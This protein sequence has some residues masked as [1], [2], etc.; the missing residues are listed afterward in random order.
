MLTKTLRAS[1]GSESGIEGK[2]RIP[3][4]SHTQAGECVEARQNNLRSTESIQKYTKSTLKTDSRLKCPLRHVG[5]TDGH[6]VTH[7]FPFK[8]KLGYYTT[9]H[10][11]QDLVS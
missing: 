3:F 11:G 5:P 9:H 4:H 10:S 6:G 8:E 2:F 1:R 7:Q